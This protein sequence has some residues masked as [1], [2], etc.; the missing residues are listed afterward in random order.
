MLP[1]VSYR[2]RFLTKE[3]TVYIVTR[4]PGLPDGYSMQNM[5]DDYA[6]MIQQEFGGPV[7]VLGTSTGGSIAQHLAAD[8]PDVVR[9]LVI[10]SSAY[11][12]GNAAREAQ[13]RVGH[14]A[15][16]RKWRKAFAAL[17]GFLL[18]FNRFGKIVAEIGAVFMILIAPD[19]ASDLVVT[20]EAED[21]HD[22]QDRLAEITAPTLV[23]GGDRDP[24]Y[25]EAMYRETAAGIPNAKL[26]IYPGQGHP[27][28]GRQFDKDVLAF[29]KESIA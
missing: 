7:D 9:R 20:I 13:M 21:Q 17:L 15:R 25:S 26:I 12:L 8:H 2:Y 23:T 19:D 14:L 22:F 5:G 16:Q 24:F 28:G 3:Y 29:L 18:S 11:A 4:K 1:P 6:V 10:H 27:V